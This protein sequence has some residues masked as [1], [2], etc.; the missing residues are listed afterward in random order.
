MD[1]NEEKKFNKHRAMS[2]E[3]REESASNETKQGYG[4]IGAGFCCFGGLFGGIHGSGGN[5][6]AAIGAGSGLLFGL[7]GG[8][9]GFLSDANWIRNT[10]FDQ[11][12]EQYKGSSPEEKV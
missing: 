2:A 1:C 5:I 8:G 4:M 9:F 3:E 11:T 6:G 10:N 12:Y 7:A